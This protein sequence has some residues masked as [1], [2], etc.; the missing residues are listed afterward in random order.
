MSTHLTK[1]IIN[2]KKKE[3]CHTDKL[4]KEARKEL[5]K[6]EEIQSKIEKFQKNA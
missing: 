6:L 4:Q 3:E 1:K 2:G 5:K